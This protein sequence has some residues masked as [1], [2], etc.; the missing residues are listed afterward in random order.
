MAVLHATGPDAPADVLQP[1]CGAEALTQL[2]CLAGGGLIAV[3]SDWHAAQ[4]TALMVLLLLLRHPAVAQDVA[5]SLTDEEDVLSGGAVPLL[6]ALA[7]NDSL[8]S[9]ASDVL[10]T[11]LNQL[12]PAQ[13]ARVV[14]PLR[15]ACVLLLSDKVLREP[16]TNMGASLLLRHMTDDLLGAL[17]AAHPL[18][19]HALRCVPSL[20]QLCKAADDDDDG[21]PLPVLHALAALASTPVGARIVKTYASRAVRDALLSG[22]P[23]DLQHDGGGSSSAHLAHATKLTAQERQ[24]AEAAMLRWRQ[25]AADAEEATTPA[26]DRVV[27]AASPAAVLLRASMQAAQP[28]AAMALVRANVMARYTLLHDCR[29]DASALP[30]MLLVAASSFVVATI[31]GDPRD[32]GPSSCPPFAHTIGIT[33]LTAGAAPELVVVEGRGSEHAGLLRGIAPHALACLLTAV[34]SAGADRVYARLDALATD[35]EA[36]GDGTISVANAGDEV[37]SVMQRLL[38]RAPV[39]PPAAAAQ[40]AWL[41][42]VPCLILDAPPED[43]AWCDFSCGAYMGRKRSTFYVD[44]AAASEEELLRM[45]TLLC[46]I[47]ESLGNAPHP[48]GLQLAQWLAQLGD[49]VHAGEAPVCGCCACRCSGQPRCAYPACACQEEGQRQ[50]LS[51]KRCSRCH[52]ARYCSQQAQAADWP[53]HKAECVAKP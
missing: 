3:G 8:S 13:R 12:L 7:A 2:L 39:A 44:A 10:R 51:F 6:L 20:K 48:A 45:P 34:C 14:R 24:A 50:K 16:R 38:G 1:L 37:L 23:Y 5:Q 35:A 30:T 32:T 4:H 43:E 15:D 40:V 53:R 49:G 11:A 42:R 21:T 41:F 9:V 36:G 31:G 52:S 26:Q 25:Q 29:S 33:H 46:S 17:P 47:A 19:Q 18:P 22:Q 28:R 27:A